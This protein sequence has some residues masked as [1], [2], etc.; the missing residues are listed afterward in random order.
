MLRP[1][2]LTLACLLAPALTCAQALDGALKKIKST[3]TV[4][5]AYRSDAAPFSFVDDAKLPV[6]YSIDLC[7]RV[8]SQ[9]AKQ[10]GAGGVQIKWVPVTTQTRME[11]VEKGQADMAC[12]ST[13]V[14][15]SQSQLVN[16]SSFIF[17]D[18]IGLLIKTASTARTLANMGGQ[19]IGVIPGTTNE[20]SLNDALERTAINA[21]VVPVK[22]CEEGL[23][24]FVAGQIGAF[25]SD[26]VC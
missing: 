8:V 24:Q 1:L 26:R 16:F 2:A 13:T 23:A 18:G 3:T 14:T 6:G 9:M 15:L 4:S 20:K 21:A 19:K 10:I 11:T 12:G 22:S 25:A 5:I 7:R 17:V